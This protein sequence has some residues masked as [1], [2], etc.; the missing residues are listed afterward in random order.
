VQQW[1]GEAKRSTAPRTFGR[2]NPVLID[3][4]SYLGAPLLRDVTAADLRRFLS[5]QSAS[6]ADSTMNLHRAILKNF[7]AWCMANELVQRTP[8]LG[9]KSFKARRDE[10][11]SRR[12]F[13]LAEVGLLYAKAPDEFWRYMVTAGFYT[14]QRLGDLATLTWGSVDF[15]ANVLRITQRKT[16]TALQIPMARVLRVRLDLRRAAIGRVKASDHVWPEQAA[17]YLA[18]GPGPLSNQFHEILSAAGLAAPRDHLAHR[19]GRAGPREAASVS[20]HCLRHTF[21]SALKIAGGSQAVAKELAGH[22]SNLVSDAYTH[23]GEKALQ[24]AIAGLPDVLA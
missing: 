10:A 17:V 4:V 14:G 13:T 7:F 8:M 2:Y 3:L 21:V 6:R 20:F 23:T 1:L 15:D 9:V 12:A 5:R 24:D 18:H 16:G 22:S 19:S 11:R